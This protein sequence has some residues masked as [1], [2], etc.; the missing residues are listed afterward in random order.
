MKI[1]AVFGLPDDVD[2]I[3]IDGRCAAGERVILVFCVFGKREVASPGG[4]AVD[5]G[6]L[7]QLVRHREEHLAE[8]EGHRE[9]A[10]RNFEMCLQADPANES[11]L[12]RLAD[13]RKFSEPGDTFLS[14]LAARGQKSNNSDVHFALGKAYEQLGDFDRAWQHFS[15]GNALDQRS[16]PAYN[17]ESAELLFNRIKE[18][19]DRKW[20]DQ[21]NDQSSEPVFICGM[22][23]T[24]STLLEQV[25]ASHPGFSAGGESEFFPRLVAREFPDYP[26]GIDKISPE[27]L[28]SWKKQHKQQNYAVF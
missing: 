25:L 22:F 3:G 20:L 19:C 5:P 13:I 14:M 17:R 12:A 24:G 6:R 26:A 2:V 4:R 7:G 18:L 15:K 16:I 21:F 10:A 27:N 23:R 9:E 28:R 1:G 11:A 8:Q